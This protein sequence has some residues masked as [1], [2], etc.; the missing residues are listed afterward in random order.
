SLQGLL[1]ISTLAAE[2]GVT[3]AA[4]VPLVTSSVTPTPEHEDGGGRDFA[5]GPIVRTRPAL[6]RFVVLTDYSHYFGTNAADDEVTS[7]VRSSVPPPV[8]TM[9]ITTTVI[10]GATSVPP[11][12]LGVGQVNPSI[13]RDFASPSMAEADVAGPSQPTNLSTG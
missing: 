6:E 3:A 13:F 11:H 4:T 12:G 7:V 9:A 10:P 1:D 5:T 2:V 8:L